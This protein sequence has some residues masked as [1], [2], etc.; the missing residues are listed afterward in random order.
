MLGAR[1]ARD[2]AEEAAEQSSTALATTETVAEES[3]GP[4]PLENGTTRGPTE[5]ELSDDLRRRTVELEES[6]QKEVDRLNAQQQ[7][8]HEAWSA[9]I[10][11]V[12]TRF[13]PKRPGTRDP[14]E[15]ARAY[16]K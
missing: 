1:M 8:L 13:G 6:Y 4:I 3:G 10:S 5:E 15:L 16:E 12:L 14:S 11:E 7:A 2:T 9:G